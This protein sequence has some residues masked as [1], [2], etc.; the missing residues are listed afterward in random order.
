MG[1]INVNLIAKNYSRALFAAAKQSG[2][3]EKIS[4]E[5]AMV[6]EA[7]SLA[8]GARDFFANPLLSADAKR[9]IAEKLIAEVSAPELK[10]TLALMVQNNRLQYLPELGVE[11]EKLVDAERGV[12]RGSI[13]SSAP[14]GED[15]KKKITDKMTDHFKKKIIFD[16]KVESQVLGGTRIQ[17]GGLTFDDSV[18]GHMNRMADELNRSRV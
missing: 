5:I 1:A 10:E 16:Y 3:H 12:L 6:A 18:E 9:E 8:D 4:G 14:L 2:A 17:V 7:F 13:T 15:V 11:Y